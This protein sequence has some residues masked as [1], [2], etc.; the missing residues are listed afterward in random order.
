MR[1]ALV[2]EWPAFC[3][4]YGIRPWEIDQLTTDELHEF[5]TQRRD[6]ERESARLARQAR[7]QTRKRG[8]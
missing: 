2:R 8:R 1:R 4:F 7:Q 3:R 5:V 6:F